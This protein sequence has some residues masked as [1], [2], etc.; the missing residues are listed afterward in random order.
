MV[1]RTLW[2]LFGSERGSEIHSE[3]RQDYLRV[4]VPVTLYVIGLDS[5]FKLPLVPT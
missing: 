2:R 1:L 3:P 4:T 5:P